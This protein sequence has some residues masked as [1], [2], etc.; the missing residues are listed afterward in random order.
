MRGAVSYLVGKESQRN[1]LVA[2]EI[3]DLPLQG[4]DVGGVFSVALD[5]HAAVLVLVLDPVLQVLGN[6]RTQGVA[7][8]ERLGHEPEDFV[9]LD[10]DAGIS[11]VVAE[12]VL[13]ALLERG[14]VEEAG[15]LSLGTGPRWKTRKMNKR[16]ERRHVLRGPEPRGRA[17]LTG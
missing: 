6:L 13:R 16:G 1:A 3:P 14:G 12:G 8:Q 5:V 9:Q 7:G 2:G 15:L 10:D 4:L 17:S 11:G